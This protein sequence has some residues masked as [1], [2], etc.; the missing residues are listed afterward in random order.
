MANT[1]KIHEK[2]TAT[3]MAKLE[4][5]HGKQANPVESNWIR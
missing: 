3:E 4:E 5:R 1:E 2:R